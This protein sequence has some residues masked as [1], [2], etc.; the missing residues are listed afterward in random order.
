MGKKSISGSGM[1]IPDHISENLETLRCGS[2]SGI[3]LTLDPASMIRDLGWKEIGSG[4]RDE[5]PDPQHCLLSMAFSPIYEGTKHM[6]FVQR[7]VNL[8]SF[9]VRICS[10]LD[11]KILDKKKRKYDQNKFPMHT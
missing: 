9:C 3:P 6:R 10:A 1:N 11:L 7:I 5:H 8:I 2:G 4:I